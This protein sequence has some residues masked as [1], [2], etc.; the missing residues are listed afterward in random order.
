M[1]LDTA[2]DEFGIASNVIPCNQTQL[3][4]F[5]ECEEASK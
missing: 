1:G 5:A 2:S 4:S 3:Q